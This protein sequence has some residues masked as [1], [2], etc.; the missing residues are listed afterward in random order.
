MNQI[1]RIAIAV[2]SFF[3]VV[4]SALSV[5]P[6]AFAMRV[7]PPGAGAS[8]AASSAGGLATWEV[9][10]ICTGAVLAIAVVTSLLLRVRFRPQVRPA[11]H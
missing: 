10:L 9:A 2:A 11:I 4:L 1:R 7:V 6:A 8:T 3:A 5:A